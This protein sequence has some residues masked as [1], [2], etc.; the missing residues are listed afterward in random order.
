MYEGRE[1]RPSRG[2]FAGLGVV[3]LLTLLLVSGATAYFY[4]RCT[5]DFWRDNWLYPNATVISE[6]SQ[7][8]SEQQRVLLTSDSPDAINEWYRRRETE[9]SREA[10]V[11]GDF[12]KMETA[13]DFR[14]VAD[15][16]G[17][18]TRIVFTRTCP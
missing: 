8:L 9:L 5:A 15:P 6:T 3:I 14:L 18:G 12:S 17:R 7:I 16:Q 10:V 2:L 11:S 4:G 1:P 13:P